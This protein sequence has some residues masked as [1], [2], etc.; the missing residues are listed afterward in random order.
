MHPA[1]TTKLGLRAKKIDVGVQ[2]ID[3]SYLDTFE[4]VIADCSVKDKLRRVRFFQETLLLANIG[5]EVVVEMLFLTFNGADIRFVEQKFVQRTYMATEALQ[6]TRRVEII[7]K[8]EFVAVVFSAD[9]EIFIVYVAALAEPIIISIYPSCQA[10]I[11]S[12]I[13]EETGISTEYF[14]FMMSFL[15]T[16]RRSYQSTSELMI[17]LSICGTISNRLRAQYIAQ[18]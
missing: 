2:K 11:A 4:M 9:N 7:D 6:T 5:L 3:G 16:L 12:L 13:S 1:Y 15:Q 18:S 14:N 17:T 8:K 10:Q